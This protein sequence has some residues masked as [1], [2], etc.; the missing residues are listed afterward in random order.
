MQPDSV[1]TAF[2][3]EEAGNSVKELLESVGLAVAT[4]RTT[5]EFL[6][7]YT[8]DP[9]GCLVLGL[10]LRGM[11]GLEL[12]ERREELGMHLPVILCT[13]H[14]SIRTAVRAMKAG[15]FDFLEKPSNE[16]EL[17]E[18][19]QQA[20]QVDGANRALRSRQQKVAECLARLTPREREVLDLLIAGN[21][22]KAICARLGITRKTL[23]IHRAN[24]MKKMET[25]HVAELF[26]L[27]LTSNAPAPRRPANGMPPGP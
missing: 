19:V 24:L 17:L 18:A 11:G 8:G 23:G 4:H 7:R 3:V 6:E 5:R 15:A 26:R 1:P 16:Q 9:P 21:H 14:G 27:V 2:L 12:L 10:R 13:A 20:I 25:H 22:N